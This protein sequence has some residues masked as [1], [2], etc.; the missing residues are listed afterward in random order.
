MQFRFSPGLG[1]LK[2]ITDAFPDDQEILVLGAEIHSW[3]SNFEAANALL[4]KA[5]RLGDN[6]KVR[7]LRSRVHF[8]LGRKEQAVD[9][10]LAAIHL[11]GT[12][13]WLV[14]QAIKDLHRYDPQRLQKDVA[15]EPLHAL[16]AE[17]KMRVAELF[18]TP[19]DSFARAEALLQ[20]ALS[21][22]EGALHSFLCTFVPSHLSIYLLYRRE[23]TRVIDVLQDLVKSRDFHSYPMELFRLALAHWGLHGEMPEGLCQPL[24]GFT[25]FGYDDEG[26]A[27]EHQ[28]LALVHWRLGERER[29]K[30]HVQK[31]L[32]LIARSE[33]PELSYW[34]CLEV[35]P[36]EFRED[37][38]QIDRLID[39]EP[40]QPLFLA[41]SSRPEPGEPNTE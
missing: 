3:E 10:L 38:R 30:E 29:A 41:G 36:D 32:S 17:A 18:A 21:D 37:C 26:A 7:L 19:E 16:S 31:A 22:A 11:P 9:D 40:L 24:S 14:V 25:W 27:C 39:G 33:K 5:L 23:W 34:R 35:S 6:P 13:P 12:P 20:E 4:D 15:W 8:Q 2:R 1:E 28:A